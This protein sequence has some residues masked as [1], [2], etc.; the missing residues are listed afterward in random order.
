MTELPFLVN[1]LRDTVMLKGLHFLTKANVDIVPDPKSEWLVEILKKNPGQTLDLQDENDF[2]SHKLEDLKKLIQCD[3]YRKIIIANKIDG[4]TLKSWIPELR[5]SHVCKLVVN[6]SNSPEVALKMR[7]VVNTER[8]IRKIFGKV[9]FGKH[10]HLL[11]R[12]T[13][14]W[15]LFGGNFV[16]S[17]AAA[18]FSPYA[19][20]WGAVG[21]LGL[22]AA[23]IASN[24]YFYKEL[25]K[26]KET[27]FWK[28]PSHEQAYLAGME[29]SK[30]YLAWFN[31]KAWTTPGYLGYV[32]QQ[33]DIPSVLPQKKVVFK[34]EV[35]QQSI[36]GTVTHKPTK[37]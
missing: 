10:E 37:Q 26:T 19:L 21:F 15:G 29:A 36:G 22:G 24:H 23:R 27:G 1:Q 7:S 6:A 8:G 35:E 2:T 12:N 28:E 34:E 11:G 16:Y 30:S 25:E 14:W 4:D 20:V 17:M 32:H 18:L 9:D 31:T 33:H 3:R 13:L 5:K